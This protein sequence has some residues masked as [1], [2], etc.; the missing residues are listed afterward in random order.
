[1]TYSNVNSQRESLVDFSLRPLM[2]SIEQRL[3]MTGMPNDFVPAS[4]EVKFDLDDYL[5]GSALERVQIYDILNRIGV[6]TVD[7]IK[8]KEDMAL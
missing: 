2:T 5:R 4:Q 7:E 8:K 1:M 6:L 3:S